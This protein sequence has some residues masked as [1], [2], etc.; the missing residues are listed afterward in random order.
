[1]TSDLQD[2][3]VVFKNN[4]QQTCTTNSNAG[5]LHK[6]IKVIPKQQFYALNHTGLRLLI[7]KQAHIKGHVEIM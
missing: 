6:M 7:G 2:S 5:S 3:H 4:Q 1:M